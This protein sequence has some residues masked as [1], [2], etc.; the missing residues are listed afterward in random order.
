MG[1]KYIIEV[2]LPAVNNLAAKNFSF[3]IEAESMKEAE[4]KAHELASKCHYKSD[5]GL[6]IPQYEGW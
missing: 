5:E 1:K 6:T 4:I 2:K 3:E